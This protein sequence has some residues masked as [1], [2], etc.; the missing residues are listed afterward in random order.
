[1]L[2]KTNLM[3]IL[4]LFGLA[5][6]LVPNL[7]NAQT[8]QKKMVKGQ[9]DKTTAVD[10]W[11]TRQILTPIE[12]KF[13]DAA[14]Y[15]NF[16]SGALPVNITVE[17][18]TADAGAPR[19]RTVVLDSARVLKEFKPG[20]DKSKIIIYLVL[21]KLTS[22]L[23]NA[24]GDFETMTVAEASADGSGANITIAF[25]PTPK[26]TEAVDSLKP[27]SSVGLIVKKD[28]G[29]ANDSLKPIT[30]VGLVVK[31]NKGGGGSAERSLKPISSIGIVVKSNQGSGR[32]TITPSVSQVETGAGENLRKTL[33]NNGGAAGRD[34][35]GYMIIVI[36]GADPNEK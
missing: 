27:I 25:S 32:L 36:G 33:V 8:T 15:D 5:F 9:T 7:A 30:G 35:I 23:W 34:K 19:K 31:S 6:W 28:S 11:K 13:G 16:A 12:I 2:R 26:V 18:T 24:D 3:A 10:D 21:E 14:T 17:I 22:P 20:T 29:S 1:M 4:T